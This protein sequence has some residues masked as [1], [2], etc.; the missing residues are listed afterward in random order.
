VH[1]EDGA[2]DLRAVGVGVHDGRMS[3]ESPVEELDQ[4]G[5]RRIAVGEVVEDVE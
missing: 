4:L 3:I 2:D 1:V 5:A